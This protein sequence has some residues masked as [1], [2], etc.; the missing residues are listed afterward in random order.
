MEIISRLYFFIILFS[1]SPLLLFAQSGPKIEFTETNH[2][3]GSFSESIGSVTCEFKFKNTGDS[4][5]VITRVTAS[6]GC[7]RPEYPKEPI[8]SGKTGK[9]KVTY[10]AKGRP[11]RFLKNVYVYANTDPDKQ[12]LYIKGNVNSEGRSTGALSGVKMEGITLKSTHLPFFEVYTRQPRVLSVGFENNTHSPLKLNFER[13][14]LHLTVKQ[15]PDVVAPGGK[16]EIEVEYDAAAAKD[17]G[18]RR[19]EFLIRFPGE[20]MASPFNKITVSADIRED[21]SGL[22]E[23]QKEKAPKIVL[24]K[25][26][27]DF[28]D[29]SGDKPVV[30]VVNITNEGKMNLQIRKVSNESSVMTATISRMSVQP[31][32]TIQLKITVNPRKTRSRLLNQRVFIITNDPVTPTVSLPVIGNFK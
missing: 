23:E 11:G 19:D 26:T 17:W 16:G 9:I 8:A 29:I 6:C 4:P 31:G 24:D 22:S 15:V 14:P 3:F 30:A 12:I 20:S 7:T 5:L 32:K 10:N 25:N 21:Y 18:M 1:F 27:V 13:V 28:R 2:D